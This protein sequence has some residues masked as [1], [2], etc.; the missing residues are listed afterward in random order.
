M[1]RAGLGERLGGRVGEQ[2]LV[3]EAIDLGVHGVGG[4]HRGTRMARHAEAI[5][6]GRTVMRRGH[7]RQIRKRRVINA[8]RILLQGIEHATTRSSPVG[9]LEGWLIGGFEGSFVGGV[10]NGVIWVLIWSGR[11]TGMTV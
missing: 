6:G 9:R 10:K 1:G 11:N 4:K 8:L 2:H 7:A 5:A 3:D